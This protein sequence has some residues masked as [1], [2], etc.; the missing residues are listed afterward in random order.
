VAP[1]LG[2][3]V[4]FALLEPTSAIVGLYDGSAS[5]VVHKGWYDWPALEEATR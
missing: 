3:N 2:I 1:L 4:F 5:A